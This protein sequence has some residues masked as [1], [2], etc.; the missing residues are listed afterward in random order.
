MSY[1]D[2]KVLSNPGYYM[3]TE[4]SGPDILP[5]ITSDLTIMTESLPSNSPTCLRFWYHLYGE[6]IGQLKVTVTEE[7]GGSLEVWSRG[8]EGGMF[9]SSEK[10]QQYS[11]GTV[12]IDCLIVL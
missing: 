5:G 12:V 9:S 1:F 11:T 6:N 10:G 8:K 3:Y 7:S 2:G 4:V